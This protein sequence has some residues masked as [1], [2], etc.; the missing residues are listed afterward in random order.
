VWSKYAERLLDLAAPEKRQDAVTCLNELI[1]NA[2]GLIPDVIEYLSNIRN[3][4]VFNFCAI[5]QVSRRYRFQSP[6]VTAN[7]TD[8]KK[9]LTTSCLE[10]WRRP[11]GHLCTLWMKTIQQDL[12]SNNLSLNEATDVA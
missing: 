1:M 11:P 4:S 10:N 9:I 2:L 7:E 3:Q 8:A 6:A 5:P 12:K